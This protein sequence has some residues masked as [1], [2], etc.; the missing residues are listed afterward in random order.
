MSS[1]KVYYKTKLCTTRLASYIVKIHFTCDNYLLEILLSDTL[2]LETNSYCNNNFKTHLHTSKL[3]KLRGYVNGVVNRIE[4]NQI[5]HIAV[6][7]SKI[8]NNKVASS[9]QLTYQ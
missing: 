9:K 6:Y 8:V 3:Q 2:L 4:T 5:I 7:T 1:L